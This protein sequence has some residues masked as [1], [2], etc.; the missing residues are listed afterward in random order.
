HGAGQGGWWLYNNASNTIPA[1]GPPGERVR[2]F[3]FAGPDPNGRLAEANAGWTSGDFV[4]FNPYT[5][6]LG[7]YPTV[8]S[9]W[10]LLDL[11]GGTLEWTEEISFTSGLFPTG[12]R[13]DGSP[14]A[15]S[16]STTSLDLIYYFGSDFPSLSTGDLG[17][18]IAA[19]IPGP[20]AAVILTAFLPAVAI[21]RRHSHM[22]R[23]VGRA[24][25]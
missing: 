14:W 22:A 13:F 11:A 8:Q 12:R 20:A 19:A 15:S 7:A 1:Y 6:P 17:F 24:A 21:R 2:E 25:G 16:M 4:G 3:P 5:I 23:E 18:R 9:P 10:G